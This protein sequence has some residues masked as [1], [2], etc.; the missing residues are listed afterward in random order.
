MIIDFKLL[1]LE[2]SNLNDILKIVQDKIQE[3]KSKYKTEKICYVAGKV[4]ADGVDGI[5]K[6]LDR[7]KAYT[8]QLDSTN[9]IFVFS[10]AD[11]FNTE[12]YW[13][14]N[15]PYPDHEYEFYEFWGEILKSGVTDIYMTPKW[16][17]SAG[18]TDEYNRAVKLELTIH[19]L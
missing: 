6:N 9:N 17:D 10:A 15:L 13:K 5:L 12:V 18:A 19:F 11:I 1:E 14:L 16:E 2:Y 8:E 3:I 7:L 4:T